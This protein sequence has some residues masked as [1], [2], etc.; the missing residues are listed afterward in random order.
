MANYKTPGVYIEEISKFPPSVA[1][2][3][4]AIPA[5][6]GYTEKAEKLNGDS[7]HMDPTRITSLLEYEQYFGTAAAETSINVNIHDEN[8]DVGEL[9]SRTIKV[10]QPTTKQPYLMFY[11]MQM[12]FANGGGPCYITSVGQYE[13]T[14][15]VNGRT[16]AGVKPAELIEGLDIIAKEDEP[17]LI[18]YPDATN[19]DGALSDTDFYA[20][21]DKAL[22]QCVKLQDRFSLIDLRSDSD[23]STPVSNFRDS[24]T[25]EVGKAKYGAAYFPFLET[26]L[27]YN[28]DE[29]VIEINHTSTFPSALPT[30]VES[31]KANQPDIVSAVTSIFDTSG[32]VD[33]GGTEGILAGSLAGAMNFLRD[34]DGVTGLGTAPG[35]TV[36]N[37]KAF[38]PLLQTLV[39][40]TKGLIDL[41]EATLN[42]IDAVAKSIDDDGG[43][44]TAG[45]SL[46][47]LRAA[48]VA[49]FEGADKIEA[50]YATLEGLISEFKT[51]KSGTLGSLAGFAADAIAAIDKLATYSEAVGVY[52]HNTSGAD[53]SLFENVNDNITALVA[54]FELIY[55]KKVDTNNGS[56]NGRILGDLNAFDNAAYNKV[57]TEIEA[58]PLTLPPSSAMAGVYARVDSTR[59]VWK[60]PANTSLSYVIKPTLQISHEEQGSLNVHTTGK[61]INAIRTFTGKGTLVWGA[62]TLAGNDN[63]WRY[64]NVRRFFNMVEESVGKASEQ[65]VFEGNDANTW[66]R[67]RAMI[68]NFLNLQWKAGALAGTKAEQAYYVRV[69]L[70][71]TMTAQDI[72]EGRM[73]IEIGM[74]AVRPAE[75]I[76][77]RFSHK[78]QEA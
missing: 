40:G 66:V 45:T 64:I 48:L 78:M 27:N 61:S 71:Q 33:A 6:I 1:Q 46:T 67:I 24:V 69:G 28:Y 5:F 58:L 2:V 37:S 56:L 15:H 73:I 72:L 47:A 16:A 34:L 74:A 57:K 26:I 9:I 23:V 60:A 54:K 49:D 7:L 32:L 19:M 17:T 31:I 43:D 36:N 59:G 21:F 55:T 63:E 51:M 50:V 75:F 29:S 10:T 39:D 11:S 3:E 68:E 65:F 14:T 62:R 44:T 22:D 12:Y 25:G 70:G 4:T 13:A 18:V 8:D 38:A 77:L 41:K 52:T 53:I 30:A 42:D 76:I 35:L 20:P